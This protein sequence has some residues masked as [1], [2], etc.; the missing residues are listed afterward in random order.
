MYKQKPTGLIR[1]IVLSF[2]VGMM[3]AYSLAEML[4]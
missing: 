1:A 3:I 4:I 2:I